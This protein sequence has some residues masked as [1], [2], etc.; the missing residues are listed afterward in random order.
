MN[1]SYVQEAA[2]SA[3]IFTTGTMPEQLSVFLGHLCSNRSVQTVHICRLI[4]ELLFGY[5]VH[6][7]EV[8]LQTIVSILPNA[9]LNIWK[10]P[11]NSQ[12]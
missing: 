8:T 6:F 1:E 3:G 10:F 11:K 7:D 9:E 5:T 2:R 12:N 4:S